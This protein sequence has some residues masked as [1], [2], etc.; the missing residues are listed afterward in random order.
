ML[1]STA[2]LLATACAAA[3]LFALTTSGRAPAQGEGK[4]NAAMEELGAAVKT[5]QAAVKAPDALEKALPEIWK[6][7]RAALDAKSE[8]PKQVSEM[9]DEKAKLKAQLAYRTQ[10]QDLMRALLDVEAAMIAGDAKKADKALRQ[11]DNLK[12]AG[13]GQF[14]PR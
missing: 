14:R 2:S 11:A 9:T 4:L 8:L 13:H 6:A 10:M 5:L 3:L 7:Q 12:S 1:K